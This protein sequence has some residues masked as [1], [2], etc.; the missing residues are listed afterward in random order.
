MREILGKRIFKNT[1][2]FFFYIYLTELIIRFNVQ[3]K[4]FDWANFRIVIS[5]IIMAILISIIISSGKTIF[6]NICATI[7]GFVIV[8]YSWAEVNLYFYL[9]FFMGTGNAEQGTKVTDYYKEYLA[10]TK[11]LTYLI[12]IL[13]IIILLYYWYIE[14]KLKISKLNKTVYFTF[15]PESRKSKISVYGYAILIFIFLSAIY[16]STL[17]V[18]FMQ[19]KLQSTSN[20]NLIIYPENSNLAVSQF[21]VVIYGISD[22]FSSI[23][24]TEKIAMYEYEYKY[25]EHKTQVNDFT[26]YVNDDAWKALIENETNSTYNNLNNYFINREITPKNEYTGI[27]EGKNLIYIL[28]ESIGEIA[29]HPELFPNI[30]KLYSEGISFK[31]NYSPRNS[32]ATGNNEM[33]SMTSLYTINNTCTANT[34]KQ[35]TYFQSVFNHFN[36]LGYA[37]SS[38]HDYAE[39]YYSRRIIHPNMGSSVYK[40]AADLGIKWSALY[41]EWP[42]DVDF[43]ETATPHF[44][45]E[46]KFMVYLTTVTTHQPYSVSSTY[47]DKHL[48]ELSEYKYSLPLKRYLSKLMELDA[49]LGLLIEK[50]KDENKLDDTVI[51]LFG[52]HY[53]Y[54][55]SSDYINEFLNYNVKENNEVD[56]TPL[57]IY[58]STQ[59]PKQVDKYTSVVDIL[60][61]VL[62]MFNVS[63]DPRLYL[64]HDIFSSY[65]D[66][67]VFADGSWQDKIGF[68]KSTT[69]KFIPK[70]EDA[71]YT[72]EEL[73]NINNEISQVQKMSAMAIKNNYFNYLKNGLEKY[74]V[75]EQPKIEE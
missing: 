57:I 31:N 48:S 73:I 33:A 58:N 29:I 19:N 39:F 4:F 66:R 70:S 15:K 20:V 14:R 17:K 64:G 72:I 55:L 56:R 1:I 2:I 28:M 50:L 60:P 71:T 53:P 65:N 6:R 36:R 49:A 5:S 41:E 42:S 63:Y 32:C 38:Y 22:L 3:S 47:G 43:I 54:G 23:F 9:G 69:T 61:T 62:N 68:Y 30:Y 51:V 16:Y 24:K 44:I 67:V 13:F 52:D 26:R 27:F 40:N 74:N 11:P 8:A 7:I 75:E 37:T 21:G 46:D 35:N 45:N 25:N 18:D 34:Y 12:I 59:E 10:A